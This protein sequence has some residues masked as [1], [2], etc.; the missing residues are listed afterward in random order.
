MKE[1]SSRVV[2]F[3]VQT[4]RDILGRAAKVQDSASVA[5]LTG[6][7]DELRNKSRALQHDLE[8]TRQQVSRQAKQRKK[9]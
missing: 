7:L 5:E 9:E 3:A 6:A 1:V 2:S 4:C 8:V